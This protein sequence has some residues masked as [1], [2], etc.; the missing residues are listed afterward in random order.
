[1]NFTVTIRHAL[2]REVRANA[3]QI[4]GK[5]FRFRFGWTMDADDAYPGETAML[6]DDPT[7]PIDA[8]LWIASGDLI[9]I[10]AQPAEL[11]APPQ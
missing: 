3:E 9:T 5:T 11:H 6:A 2:G 10:E 4:D 8:P 7:Y 1:M